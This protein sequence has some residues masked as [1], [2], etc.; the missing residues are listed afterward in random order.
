MAS[1]RFR[2]GSGVYKCEIC[3]KMTRETG[4]S[5]SFVGLCVY[6]YTVGGLQN[7]VADGQMTKEEFAVEVERLRKL[8][9][10]PGHKDDFRL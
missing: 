7:S 4:E 3:G 5:E 1:N 9:N 8:H 10:H 2:K 6:C